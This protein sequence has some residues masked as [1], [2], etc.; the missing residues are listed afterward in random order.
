M[1]DK[2]L[3]IFE[4]CERLSE[5]LGDKEAIA[6]LKKLYTKHPEMFKDMQDVSNTIKEVVN[7]PTIITEAK[8]QD[9]ILAVKK[10]EKSYK[11]GEIAIEND[12]GTNVIFHAN[13]KNI[14][15]F[16]EKQILVETPSANAAPTW[17]N[18]CADNL[19]KLSKCYEAPSISA[20]QTIPQKDKPVKDFKAKLKEFANKKQIDTKAKEIEIPIKK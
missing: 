5:L 14:S 17:S 15:K 7:N 13:K 8:R 12:N 1:S 3:E 6:D 9:A 20:K 10:L 11:V 19:N 4:L 18:R 2:E 16:K